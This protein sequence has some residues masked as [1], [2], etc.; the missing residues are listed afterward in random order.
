[1]NVLGSFSFFGF[2]FVLFLKRQVVSFVSQRLI[3][4][5]HIIFVLDISLRGSCFSQQREENLN[6]RYS[7][8]TVE[9]TGNFWISQAGCSLRVLGPGWLEM[10]P[11]LRDCPPQPG[12]QLFRPHPPPCW[13]VGGVCR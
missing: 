3:V 1:M 12:A 4:N 9:L 5:N 13:G 6:P 11:L 7:V 2:F 10:R 8:Q